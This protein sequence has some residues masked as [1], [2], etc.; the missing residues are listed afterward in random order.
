MVEK[1]IFFITISIKPLRLIDLRYYGLKIDLS[2]LII[3]FQ[4]VVD[5]K[6]NESFLVLNL[7]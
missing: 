6:A 4:Q 3:F 1:K 5:E 2:S 7:K